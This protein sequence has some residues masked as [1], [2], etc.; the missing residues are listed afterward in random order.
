MMQAA[1]A[2]K[3]VNGGKY[4]YQYLDGKL[5]QETRGEKSF[6]YYYDAGGKVNSK[7]Y[8]GDMHYYVTDLKA[9]GQSLQIMNMAHE[10]S[11][12]YVG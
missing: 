1:F 8:A 7:S 2:T 4:T 9:T 5:S 12:F 6:H 10:A 3:T 11:C